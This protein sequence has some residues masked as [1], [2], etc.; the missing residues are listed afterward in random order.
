MTPRELEAKRIPITLGDLWNESLLQWETLGVNPTRDAVSL[1]LAH[2]IAETGLEHCWNYN[3]GNKK[4]KIGDG[5]H[6]QFFACGEELTANQLEMAR[7]LGKDLVTF[8]SK[9]AR[10]GI[11]YYSCRIK[12]RH[13]W[14]RFQAFESLAGGVRAQL[15][16]LKNPKH[17]N[18]LAALQTGD[19]AA[20]NRELLV[21]KYY[22]AS[23]AAYLSLLQRCLIDV[24]RKTEHFDWG[25]V[26]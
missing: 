13:P 24:K 22:T 17:D 21:D 19:P 25:D 12:P 4:S 23:P 1:Y 3:I 9:Y 18:V 6:W 10:N 8:V 26:V 14:C 5:Q 7:A 15:A 11:T 2:V 16:Y 20:Y